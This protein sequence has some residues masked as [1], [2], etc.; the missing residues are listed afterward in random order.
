[1]TSRRLPSGQGPSRGVGRRATR[2]PSAARAGA[3]RGAGRFAHLAGQTSARVSGAGRHHHDGG[4]RRA[5][6]PA[7][8]TRPPRRI[9]TRAAVLVLLL[10]AL[11]LA[12][13]YPVR[14]YLAQQAEIDRMRAAQ[15]EQRERIRQLSQELA[16]WDD[17]DYVTSQA[18]SR[19]QWVPKGS[20]LYVVVR[21]QP[22]APGDEDPQ[23]GEAW[24]ERLWGS[25]QAA[26]SLP[27]GT[28]E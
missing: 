9:S 8:R 2:R 16:R 12:Y 25:V 1:M 14:T 24:Y 17:P 7:R 6:G 22:L 5:A 21:D 19:I 18:A 28:V 10:V 20:L 23:T 3:R 27:S 13:G 11:A 4:I 26:D 15:Q